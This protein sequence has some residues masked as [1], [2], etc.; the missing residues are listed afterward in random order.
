MET[1]SQL[2]FLQVTSSPSTGPPVLRLSCSLL[3]AE[4]DD[5]HTYLVYSARLLW[6]SLSHLEI[7]VIK[8][9]FFFFF[10]FFEIQKRIGLT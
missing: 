8:I 4:I 3:P 7:E 9:D 6:A 10:F 1:K 2:I 5:F